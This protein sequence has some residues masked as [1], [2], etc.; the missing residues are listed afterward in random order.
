MQAIRLAQIR[1]DWRADL[2]ANR[3]PNTAELAQWRRMVSSAPTSTL[4]ITNGSSSAVPHDARL[5]G[6]G[7]SATV[8]GNA[9][10]TSGGAGQSRPPAFSGEA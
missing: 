10:P 6:V 7:H 8:S 1:A 2:R 5:G 3:L 9:S 4:C